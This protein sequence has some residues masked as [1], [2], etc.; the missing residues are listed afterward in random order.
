MKNKRKIIIIVVCVIAAAAI[1][2]GAGVGY[3]YSRPERTAEKVLTAVYTVDN[4]EIQRRREAIDN[5]TFDA[6]IRGLCDGAVTDSCIEGMIAT[7]PLYYNAAPAKVESI[8]LSPIDKATSDTASFQYTVVFEEGA[9]LK[10]QSGHVVVKKE[11]GKWCVSGFA[12]K[13]ITRAD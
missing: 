6:Y 9:A 8:K 13:S 10:E 5:R 2:V 11:N 7:N 3:Y 1:A 4:A 12:T